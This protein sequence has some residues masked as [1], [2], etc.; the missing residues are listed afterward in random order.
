[1]LQLNQTLGYYTPSFFK[2][3]IRSIDPIELRELNQ[4]QL[5]TFVH[6]YTHFIQDFTTIIGLQNIYNTFERLRLYLTET[7]KSRKV[8]IPVIFKNEVLSINQV[9][10]EK[11]WGTITSDNNLD[12]INVIKNIICVTSNLGDAILSR[13]S[14]LKSFRIVK[15]T[16]IT[17]SGQDCEIEIGTLAIMESMAYLAEGLMGLPMTAVP[18]YPYNTVKLMANTL[19]P[20]K[21]L[22]DEILYA[23]CDVALQCSSPGVAMFE[24]LNGIASDFRPMPQDG[25]DV[26]RIFSKA[27]NEWNNAAS[28]GF[29]NS[30]IEC[31]SSLIKDPMGSRYQAW[32]NNMMSFA[33]NMRRDRPDY[34]ISEIKQNR[35]YVNIVNLVG[36]PLMVN[37]VEEYSKVPVAFPYNFPVEMDVEFFRAIE[38]IMGVFETGKRECPLIEWC[39]KSN[40][41]IDNNCIIN[42]PQRSNPKEYLE[43]CPVSGIWRH[44][45]LSR[46]KLKRQCI[47]KPICK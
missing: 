39:K 4:E 25:Y 26:Y 24:M 47:F 3:Y 5:A 33:V 37:A 35:S 9:V 18:D 13:F 38:Y 30:A 2:I 40:I 23:L 7:Y 34:L 36:T 17:P 27:F 14:I 21:K 1:M 10:Y 15:A 12:R 45:N 22:N 44:W 11:S 31:L 19:C 32:I 46:Y 20:K 42:P 6:E 43:L 41:K 8:N 28:D 16:V 29:V